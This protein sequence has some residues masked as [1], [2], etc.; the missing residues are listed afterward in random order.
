[1]H[2]T[3][4]IL[5]YHFIY[6]LFT[7]FIRSFTISTLQLIMDGSHMFPSKLSSACNYYT[8]DSKQNKFGNNLRHDKSV[9]GDDPD[10]HFW[11]N[12]NHALTSEYYNE[13]SFNNTCSDNQN[14]SLLY[15]N[16]RSVPLHFTECLS[17]L[18]T[19]NINFKIIALCETAIVT[20]LY[21]E[22][23]TTI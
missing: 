9:L 18:D 12:M 15:L 19:L 3:A 10:N 6:Y 2:S 11:N 23:Q 4:F 1:M 14:L 16:I 20:T 22:C 13:M 17:Y 21:I 8:D 5:C 7:E